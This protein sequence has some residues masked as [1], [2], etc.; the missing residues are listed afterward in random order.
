VQTDLI[1]G[2]VYRRAV[3]RTKPDQQSTKRKRPSGS[4][5]R[6]QG[7]PPEGSDVAS[8]G[9]GQGEEDTDSAP[10]QVACLLPKPTT[11]GS[12]HALCSLQLR[13]CQYTSTVAT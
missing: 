1:E 4:G 7:P 10:P 8:G 5:G 9:S 13:P 12:A 2:S 3:G 6:G 11:H